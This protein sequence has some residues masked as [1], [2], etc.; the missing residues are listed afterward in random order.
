MNVHSLF[1]FSEQR[2]HDEREHSQE[3]K[4]VAQLDDVSRSL[5]ERSEL[6]LH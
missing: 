4:A 1:V 3:N 2:I 5:G 6:G